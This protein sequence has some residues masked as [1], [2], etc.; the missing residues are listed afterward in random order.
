MTITRMAEAVPRAFTL[1]DD[2][3][4]GV[5]SAVRHE[6][7]GGAGITASGGSF[8]HD[9]I[10]VHITRDIAVQLYGKHCE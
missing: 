5:K 10:I 2:F 9:S 8:H 6:C 1:A 4:W 7:I 3:A